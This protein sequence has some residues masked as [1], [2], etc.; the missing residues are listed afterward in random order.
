[1]KLS[2]ERK[3]RIAVLTVIFNKRGL[4]TSRGSAATF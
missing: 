4:L 2:H 3:D 1:M